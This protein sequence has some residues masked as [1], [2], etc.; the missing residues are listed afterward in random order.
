M[1]LDC[2]LTYLL[3]T[4]LLYSYLLTY[5]YLLFSTYLLLPAVSYSVALFPAPPPPTSVC[6]SSDHCQEPLHQN[7]SGC[8]KKPIIS[9]FGHN[10]CLYY[11][12]AVGKSAGLSVCRSNTPGSGVSDPSA[13]RSPDASHVLQ[14]RS[15]HALQMHYF[16]EVGFKLAPHKFWREKSD[17]NTEILGNCALKGRFGVQNDKNHSLFKIPT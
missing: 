1:P 14:K 3:T 5:S 8:S 6:L 11:Q 12:R 2:R 13:A 7:T 9:F 10:V 4:Y 16:P 17:K 15:V